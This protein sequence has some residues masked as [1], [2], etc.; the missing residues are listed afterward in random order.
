MAASAGVASPAR[1]TQAEAVPAKVPLALRSPVEDKNFFVFAAL[2]QSPA[3][4]S[5]LLADPELGAITRERDYYLKLAL[6]S[7][8]QDIPCT[9]K[10]LLWT[11][12]EIGAVS[13]SLRDLYRGNEAL[14]AMVDKNLRESGAYLLFAGLGGEDL[15]VNAWESCAHGLNNIL[16]VYGAGVAPRY[17]L[18]DSISVDIQSDDIKQQVATLADQVAAQT[19]ALFFEPSLKAALELLRL[20]HRDEAGRFEPMEQGEN[21]AAL[22]AIPA[23]QWSK[24]SYSVIVVP[25]AGPEDPNVALS[26]AGRQRTALAAERYHAGKAPLI[27]VSGGYV[28]PAQTR[29]SE[30]IEMKRALVED[31]HVPESA[32]LVDPH[33]RHTTTNLRNAAREIYRY[34]IPMNKPVLVISDKGQIHSIASEAFADRNLKELGYLPYQLINQL[35]ETDLVILPRIESLQMDPMDP[36]DP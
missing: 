27:L 13:R 10:A 2:E 23:I 8:K 18:I 25:G 11:D 14:R 4:R 16:S 1:A 20:N 31:Y 29:F 24:Y 12:E 9:I 15:L 5:A 35:S 17:P 28:H 34:G 32:I 3:V 33:A 6:K 21:K 30:A 7:C 26:A 19:P 36:L 22:E